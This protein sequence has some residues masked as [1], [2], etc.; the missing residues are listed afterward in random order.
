MMR[1]HRGH[2][3][4]EPSFNLGI[5]DPVRFAGWHIGFKYQRLDCPAASHWSTN[6]QLSLRHLTSDTVAISILME[7]AFYGVAVTYVSSGS[8]LRLVRAIRPV[9]STLWSQ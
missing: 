6:S 7:A 3:I 2:C 5:G 9:H 1:N 8:K 4:L